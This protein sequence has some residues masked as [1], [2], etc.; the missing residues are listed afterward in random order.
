MTI[1]GQTLFGQAIKVM[2]NAFRILESSVPPPKMLPFK[3][4]FVFRYS[5]KHVEQALV[6]KLVRVISGLHAIRLLLKPGLVQ[7][8]DVIQ[9]TLDELGEDVLFLAFGKTDE[10]VAPLYDEYLETFWAEVFDG[11]EG[12]EAP[13]KKKYVAF[14]LKIR[15][16][17]NHKIG[18]TSDLSPDEQRKDAMKT[19][20]NVY[21]GF[22]HSASPQIMDVYGGNP[23]RFHIAGMLGTPRVDEYRKDS[24]NY[25]FRSLQSFIIVAKVFGDKHL[26]ESLNSYFEKFEEESKAIS[27]WNS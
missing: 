21:S 20:D 27:M 9:R 13:E 7:E 18:I 15:K 16:Y 3:N 17:L 6:Q 5:E 1:V 12:R 19:L 8:Q 4:S 25:F 23:P 26:V 11:L 2:E 10:D 24:W 22:V 14:R